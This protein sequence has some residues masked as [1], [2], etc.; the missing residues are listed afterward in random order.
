[1]KSNNNKNKTRPKYVYFFGILLCAFFL[2]IFL[3][4]GLII[5]YPIEDYLTDV[6]DEPVQIDNVKFSPFYPNVIS[7]NG[8]QTQSGISVEQIYTEYKLDKI[9]NLDFSLD[10]AELDI[11]NAKIPKSL[12]NHKGF[13]LPDIFAKKLWVK[14]ISLPEV[15]NVSYK[16]EFFNLDFETVKKYR[17]INKTSRKSTLYNID[18]LLSLV[19]STKGEIVYNETTILDKHVKDAKVNFECVGVACF[20]SYNFD[21]TNGYIKGNGLLDKT[22]KTL[23][24]KSLEIKGIKLTPIENAFGYNINIP[25]V[26]VSNIYLENKDVKLSDFTGQIIH[27]FSNVATI[28]GYFENLELKGINLRTGTISSEYETTPPQ[29]LERA[30]RYKIKAEYLDGLLNANFLIIG[31]Q[32]FFD[33]LSFND[34]S[35]PLKEDYLNNIASFAPELYIKKLTCDDCEIVSYLKDWP[36]HLREVTF[37][38]KDLKKGKPSNI[39]IADENV[40]ASSELSLA[41]SVEDE[42]ITHHKYESLTISDNTLSPIS[43]KYLNSKGGTFGFGEYVLYNT[44][45]IGSFYNDELSLISD[46]AI[47]RNSHGNFSLLYPLSKEKPLLISINTPSIDLADVPLPIFS[48]IVGKFSA[49]LKLEL[50]NFDGKNFDI[51]KSTIVG[52]IKSKLF[53]LDG[54][55]ID[56][57]ASKL[58]QDSSCTSVIEAY[59]ACETSIDEIKNFTLSANLIQGL[60]KLEA[61]GKALTGDFKAKVLFNKK[62]SG[63][64]IIEDSVTGY[65]SVT[66]DY[67]DAPQKYTIL[68]SCFNEILIPDAENEQEEN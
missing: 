10:L 29:T 61:S 66:S 8:L 64:D 21:F 3:L 16:T 57:F 36:L 33:E 11:I 27:P 28:N 56:T 62:L 47:M 25:T 54:F 7:I 12:N 4:S 45:L 31:E 35:L 18:D 60:G 2:V 30:P 50:I 6:L 63:D 34:I 9:L 59:K 55:S 23:T 39:K 43:F 17:K 58:N 44:N 13:K 41:D 15:G 38:I 24:T 20:I 42:N 48:N 19:L 5:K 32:V 37:E 46:K 53:T 68:G 52:N 65:L 67:L 14:N 51:D 49:V 40:I 26:D 1:M 22:D